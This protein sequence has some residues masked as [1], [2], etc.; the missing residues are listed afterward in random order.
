VYLEDFTNN[1]D[2]TYEE[3]AIEIMADEEL[4]GELMIQIFLHSDLQELEEYGA[5]VEMTLHQY[6]NLHNWRA[7][8]GRRD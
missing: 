7:K 2:A 4:L 5:S 6:D 8:A 1:E 3:L